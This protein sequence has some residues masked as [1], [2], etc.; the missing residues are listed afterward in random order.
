[1]D[2]STQR[3]TIVGLTIG[4]PNGIGPEVAVKAALAL[5][6][7][8]FAT[9]LMGDAEVIR[10][11]AALAGVGQEERIRLLDRPEDARPVPG[12]INVCGAGPAAEIEAGAVTAEA[13]KAAM[14]WLAGA[15]KLAAEGRI[16]AVSCAPANKEAMRLAGSPFSGQT[17]FIASLTGGEP[18]TVL[19]SGPY[20]VFQATTHVPLRKACD[21]ITQERIIT[22]IRQAHDILTRDFGIVN[23]L[24]AVCGLNPH[25][26][27]GGLLGQEEKSHIIPAIEQ[28]KQE[29]IRVDGP[30]P[31]DTAFVKVRRQGHDGVVAMYHDQANVI[32]KFMSADPVT[33][34]VGLPIVRTTVGH[35]TAHDIAGRGIADPG[36]MTAAVIIAAQLAEARRR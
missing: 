17:E 30:L 2:T 22:H 31:G 27:D 20:R 6:D 34:T 18:G 35:G 7:R 29:G 15:V 8:E 26:G 33:V 9:V 3:P 11:A 14:G 28:A 16:D 24:I 13:G 21:L 36:C 4:D 12:T 19:V 25:S 5:G 23:P 1:M 10:R 32:L